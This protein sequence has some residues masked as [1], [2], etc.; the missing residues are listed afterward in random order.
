MSAPIPPQVLASMQADIDAGLPQFR[1][2]S[3]A[4]VSTRSIQRLVSLGH[5]KVTDEQFKSGFTTGSNRN[6]IYPWWLPRDL[7]ADYIDN[8]RLYGEEH[9]A[10]LARAAKAAAQLVEA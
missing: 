8:F 1:V 4:G 6:G 5:L 2:A 9:A 7:R 3:R 10:R